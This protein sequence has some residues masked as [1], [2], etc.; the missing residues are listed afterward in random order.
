MQNYIYWVRQYLWTTRDS[1]VEGLY[2]NAND[3][4]V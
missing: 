3:D 1:K 4:Y 2:L